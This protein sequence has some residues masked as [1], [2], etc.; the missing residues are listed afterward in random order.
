MHINEKAI[1]FEKPIS[2]ATSYTKS[3][4]VSSFLLKKPHCPL[5]RP[6]FMGSITSGLRVKDEANILLDSKEWSTS[7]HARNLNKHPLHGVP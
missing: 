2:V 7:Y 5:T 4:F 1:I 3:L 6:S